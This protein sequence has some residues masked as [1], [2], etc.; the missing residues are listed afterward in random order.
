MKMK[1]LACPLDVKAVTEEG[2]FE[3]Y[4]SV[5]GTLDSYGERVAAGAFADT[6][7]KHKEAGTM[8]ALL[9]QHNPS[10][11][12]GRYTEMREDKRGLFVKGQ[13]ATST[14]LGRDAYEL[15]KM[16]AVG[17]LSI[18]FIPKGEEVEDDGTITL[19][20]IDLWETSIV[21]FPANPD[22]QIDAVRARVAAGD[23]PTKRDTEQLL[24]DAGF[25]RQQAKALLSAGYA[26]L[27]T[28]DAQELAAANSLIHILE[29]TQ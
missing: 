26:G 20:K 29:G 24:R 2:E 6:L 22:A 13:I 3:G 23:V 27:E 21:T 18:G 9:W 8:P 12:I 4:G 10:Q 19:T 16:D 5:F 7:A 17:G 11:P 15:L 25:S 14:A 28:R 1:H